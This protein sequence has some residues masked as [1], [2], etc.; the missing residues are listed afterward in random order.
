L[1]INM[2]NI[3]RMV[4]IVAAVAVAWLAIQWAQPE[5]LEQGYVSGNGRIEA[6]EILIAAKTPGRLDE[7][8][9]GEGGYVEAGQVLARMNSRV[10]DA[11]RQEAEAQQHQA[12]SSVAIA[13]SQIT[14]RASE[15]AAAEAAVMQ[16]TAELSAAQNRFTRSKSLAAKGA[17]SAQLL[18]DERASVEGAQAA[19]A[20]AKA[21]VV[22][23]QAMIE[24]SKAQLT[25]AES[26]V[27]AAKATIERI[28]ADIDDAEL[29]APRDGRVQYL[30]AQPGEV[31]G[32]GGN[33]LSMVD[34]T[35]VYMTFFLPETVA[36]RVAI[37]AEVRL[38]VDA[39]PD[40]AIPARI[41][42]VANVAQFTPKTVETELER[43]KLMFR[44]KA[45]IDP[46][47]LEKHIQFVKTGLPGVAYVQLD[48]AADWPARIPDQLLE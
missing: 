40:W 2:K 31:L 29:R 25:G 36:G 41:S 17:V 39:A 34:L 24:T 13:H 19:L 23:N 10:L 44:V 28:Q 46:L 3:R 30:V 12:I 42:F 1:K 22:A 11:Q 8:L 37:G 9:V 20:A 4:I 6:V 26:S 27:D 5:P 38:V 45:R 14:Q 47:L 32:A 48:P 43:Q 16:R 33:V 35:D 18:D 15:L 21:Q 7:I